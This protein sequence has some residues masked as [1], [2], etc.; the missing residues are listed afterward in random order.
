MPL[1]DK[2]VEVGAQLLEHTGL[3]EKA[4]EVLQGAAGRIMEEV[5]LTRAPRY[6]DDAKSAFIHGGNEPGDP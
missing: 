3:G 4:A 2:A 1:A 6:V 5:G